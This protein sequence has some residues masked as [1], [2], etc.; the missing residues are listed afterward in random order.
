MAASCGTETAEL[1]ASSKVIYK[2]EKKTNKP[3]TQ[4]QK[5]CK[6]IEKSATKQKTHTKQY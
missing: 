6:S 3:H 2:P 1:S 5:T 4:Q